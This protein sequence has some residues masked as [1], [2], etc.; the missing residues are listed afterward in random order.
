MVCYYLLAQSIKLPVTHFTVHVDKGTDR[1]QLPLHPFY[2]RTLYLLT[3][4]RLNGWI[5]SG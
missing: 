5:C 3:L 4:F 1:K 2:S